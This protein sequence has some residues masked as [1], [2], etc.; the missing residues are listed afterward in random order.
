MKWMF[1]LALGLVWM[2]NSAG[3][4]TPNKKVGEPCEKVGDGFTGK[5]PC[6]EMCVGW[7]ITCPNGA[8]VTPAVCAGPVCGTSGVCPDGLVCLQVDSFAANSRC[9]PASVCGMATFSDDE[10]ISGL[11]DEALD[12]EPSGNT[13]EWIPTANPTTVAP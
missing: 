7:E 8:I 3:S 10:P 13:D 12:F 9:M 2:L 5:D 4:C 11:T 1:A 6:A